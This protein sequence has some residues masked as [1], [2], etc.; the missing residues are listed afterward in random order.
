MD[1]LI[2]LLYN[3][4]DWFWE[5]GRDT[6]RQSYPYSNCMVKDT[7]RIPGLGLEM[8]V[9]QEAGLKKLDTAALLLWSLF[10]IYCLTFSF[11]SIQ[12]YRGFNCDLDMGNMLQAFYNSLDGRFM[13]MTWNGTDRAGC[14][15]MGHAEI[16]FLFLL[17]IFA[18]FRS[19]LTLLVMQS[20][21]IGLG[22]IAVF[23]LARHLLRNAK[24]AVALALCYW[25]FPLLAAINLFE[26]HADSFIIAPH[27]FAYYFHRTGRAKWFWVAIICGFLVKEHAFLFTVLLG[28]MI[29][30]SHRTRGCLL[31]ALGLAQFFIV[32]PLLQMLMGTRLQ[33]NLQAHVLGISATKDP[34][35]LV[36][37]YVTSFIHGLLS[38]NAL[39]VMVIALI[40][41]R[42]CIRFPAGLIL[43]VPLCALF[44]AA[45]SVLSH[46]HA[47]LIAPV[48]ILLCEGVARLPSVHRLRD[49]VVGHLI[50]TTVLLILFPQSVIGLNIRELLIK[51]HR[52]VF[53]Y[54]YTQHDAIADSLIRTVPKGV[55][56][57]AD[58]H[59]RSKLADRKWAFIH[60][61][62][63]DS[64]RADFFLFDFFERREYDDVWR[65]RQRVA[66]LMRS[67]NFSLLSNTDGLIIIEKKHA[68]GFN[69]MW[70]ERVQADVPIPSSGYTVQS[71]GIRPEKNGYIMDMRFCKGSDSLSGSAFISLFIDRKTNDT[72]RVLHLASYTIAKLEQLNPGFF[73]ES[74][75]FSIPAG[76]QFD[77]RTHEI[78]LY[79]KNLY[80]PF[81]ARR[82]Y[83]LECLYN[84][85]IQISR[86]D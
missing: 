62:P 9:K 46:R 18:L 81:F 50:P 26:F 2:F 32:T 59:L 39:F 23:A 77:T 67:G 1:A 52:N 28:I 65:N 10:G 54:A 20:V 84:E 41:N 51:N 3:H 15:W 42:A 56:I 48:F 45:G 24:A 11:L 34:M 79:H 7:W 66:A 60:P 30:R 40:L 61:Y 71:I 70:L 12:E 44:I 27:L 43:L 86:N 47:I 14:M 76:K 85:S 68:D 69:A 38:K 17:P 31:I 6:L 25:L 35:F 83:R 78:W 49:V 74:F 82:E 4:G 36:G 64:T 80:L 22:G 55:P 33:L 8:S 21:A 5:V 57:A 73:Q 16:V 72:I 63:T 19:P 29:I 53:H 75:W 58:A 13:E 37:A